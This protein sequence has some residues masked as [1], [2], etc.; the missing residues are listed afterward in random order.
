MVAGNPCYTSFPPSLPERTTSAATLYIK[1]RQGVLTPPVPPE[2]GQQ[3]RLTVGNCYGPESPLP[4]VGGN[5]NY[6]KPRQTIT[7]PPPTPTAAD[8]IRITVGNCYIPGEPPRVVTPDTPDSPGVTYRRPRVGVVITPPPAQPGDLVRTIVDNCYGPNTPTLK[9]DPGPYRPKPRPQV[10]LPPVPPNGSEVIRQLVD[11]CYGPIGDP[12]LPDPGPYYPR[13]RRGDPE[14]PPESRPGEIIRQIVDRCYPEIVPEADPDPGDP[15][16]PPTIPLFPDPRPWDWLCQLFPDLPICGSDFGPIVPPGPPFDGPNLPQGPDCNDVEIGLINKTV[17]RHNYPKETDKY[18]FVSGRRKGEIL[19]CDRGEPPDGPE[20]PIEPCVKEYLSCLF[21]PYATGTYRS[22]PVSCDTFYFRGQNSVTKKICVANCH[23]ERI[24]IYE[25]TL[26]GNAKNVVLIPLAD[27]LGSGSGSF[28]KH[29]LRVVTTDVAGNYN[30]K[31]VFCVAGSKYFS[32]NNTITK[33][34]SLGGA[35]VTFKIEPVP[36]GGND[37]DSRW[38]IES[39]SGSLPAIGTSVDYTFNAG[40]RDTTVKLQVIGGSGTAADHRYGLTANPDM[41]GY[42]TSNDGEP[43]FYIYKNRERG[44]VPLYRFYSPTL[45]DTFLTIN[46]GTPDSKGAGERANINAGGYGDAVILGNVF[47]NKDKSSG[48]LMQGEEVQELYRYFNGNHSEL[49]VQFDSSGNLVCT[50]TGSGRVPVKIDWDDSRADDGRPFERITVQGQTV[51]R[52]SEKGSGSM[53]VNVTGGQTV[54]V[55]YQGRSGNMVRK[56]GNYTLSLGD[57][58][59]SNNATIDIGQASGGYNPK[60]NHKYSVIKQARVE[61]PP[62]YH[63]QRKSYKIPS[64]PDTPFTISYKVKKGSAGYKNSWGVAITDED[65]SQIYWNR[66]IEANTTRDIPVTQYEIPVDTLRQY[67]GKEI[68]FFLLPDGG[69][70]GASDNQS[71][72]MSKSGNHYH[73]SLS[74]EDNHVFFSNQ[75]MN[76]DNRNKVQYKGNHEQWWEDLDG[77][78]SD[79]DYD[80]FKLTYRIG[81]PA[82]EWEYEGIECYVFDRPSPEP[83]LIPIIVREACQEPL[84]NGIFRDSFF[85]RSECGP[86]TSPNSSNKESRAKSGKCR[87]EYTSTINRKQTLTAQRSANLS[88]RA[89]GAMIRAP[90]VEE[91]KI[92]FTLSKNGSEFINWQGY[93]GVWPQIGYNFGDFSVSKGDKI[94]WKIEEIKRGPRSG[95]ASLGFILF[96]RDEEVF[97]KPWNLDVGTMPIT[98]EAESR[99]EVVSDFPRVG[100]QVGLGNI[101]TGGR[102]KKMSIRLWD[103]KSK[104]WTPKVTIWDN[105]QVDTNNAN[106]QDAEWNDTYYGGSEFK[107]YLPDEGFY[108]G[109]GNSRNSHIMSSNIDPDGSFTGK[110]NVRNGRGIFYNGLFEH[111]RGLICKPSMD[112]QALR[113]YV[114]M[115]NTNGFVAWFA[116]FESQFATDD[117]A[118]YGNFFQD[119]IADFDEYYAKGI[120]A[121][122]STDFPLGDTVTSDGQ[123]SKMSFMHDFTLGDIDDEKKVTE[124]GSSG[125][126]R[127]AFWPYTVMGSHKGA[128]TPHYANAIYWACAV[129]CFDVLNRGVAYAKG[130]HFDFVWPPKQR[131]KDEYQNADALG[132]TT[133]YYPRDRNAG[134]RIPDRLIAKTV[135]NEDGDRYDDTYSPKEVFYQESHNRDSNLWFLCQS[136]RKLDRVKFRIIIEEVE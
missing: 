124:E 82:S 115:S 68:V 13:P 116:Q 31:K 104:Q 136:D 110:P 93:I 15:D 80:D 58:D 35:S 23:P 126:I 121:N 100:N 19:T 96:D 113:D 111:G 85:I 54:S 18:R 74:R 122:S 87:G 25:Y 69:D 94:K 107:D 81:M 22:P 70:R 45:K 3:V 71:V 44:T 125:K 97:E 38:W 88:L 84:F 86:R 118:E 17:V 60:D 27:D 46:P 24:P 108:E 59:S 34:T 78:G 30:G 76:N 103:K 47:A 10:E 131:Q 42:T 66:I 51:I 5:P 20:P 56:N 117:A 1:P 55:N 101:S 39:F 106:G 90:E 21:K 16:L 132:A 57:S 14:P 8:A 114:H 112:N 120:N 33:T 79:E 135:G 89:F 105:G 75:R 61:T 12:L 83:T 98:A 102:I 50:G 11:N 63:P 64:D 119:Q 37:K 95:L 65:G 72:S 2:P 109:G 92:R 128:G 62:R 130:Q 43:A 32:N 53:M 9:P 4:T 7:D 52:D 41:P 40:L 133:P 73:S 36:D 26:T 49:D 129:E 127:M 29:N 123:Y 48:R 99:S 28:V 77:S 67:K 6:P 91:M 134:H